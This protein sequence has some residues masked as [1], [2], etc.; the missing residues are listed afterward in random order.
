MPSI[1]TLDNNI[2]EFLYQIKNSMDSKQ[3]WAPVDYDITFQVL[4]T[5]ADMVQNSYKK[6]TASSLQETS[7][8]L[9]SDVQGG[10]IETFINYY[11]AFLFV[12]K[13][14]NN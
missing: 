6:L 10:G 9:F 14:F 5:A 1:Y 2:L 8:R 3:F 4:Q 7:R 13:L 12:R 11:N